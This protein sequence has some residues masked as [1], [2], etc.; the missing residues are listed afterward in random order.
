V[1]EVRKADRPGGR[2]MSDETKKV[3]REPIHI[4]D[5]VNHK[6]VARCGATGDLT[7]TH[8]DDLKLNECQ[9]CA[10]FNCSWC[11]GSQKLSDGYETWRCQHCYIDA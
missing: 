4:G 9:D 8:G 10:S 3:D 7:Y 6:L 11:E 5:F 1:S 2:E